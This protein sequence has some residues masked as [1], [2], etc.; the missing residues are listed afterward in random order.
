[1][2]DS[3]YS[4]VQQWIKSE[5]NKGSF[6]VGEKIPSENELMEKFNF[7]RQ[8]I[9]LAISNLENE[10]YVEKVKGSGTFVKGKRSPQSKTTKNI[11][12]IVRYLDNF[13]NP[14]IIKG[15][16]SILTVNG[17]NILLGITYNKW[18]KE[19]ATLN[20]MLDK[21]IDGLLIE[22]CKTAIPSPNK[23]IY[24]KIKKNVPCVFINHGYSGIEIPSVSMDGI[25]G[26]YKAANCLIKAGHTQ[27]ACIFKADDIQGHK[28]YEGY[29]KALRHEG[30]ALNDKSCIWYNS[31]DMDGLL[32]ASIEQL[33]SK[34]FSNCTAVIC[35]NDL[36]AISVINYMKKINKK[37]FNDLSLIS[38]GNSLPAG[39]FD[40]TSISHAKEVLGIKAA[41]SLLRQI[42]TGEASSFL[43]EPEIIERD[44]VVKKSF[45]N[46]WGSPSEL[47]CEN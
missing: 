3:K 9:R 25:S 44:S 18:E 8:T 34:R 10:G 33:F 45:S 20:A 19:A 12:V 6:K 1:M 23:D 5:I 27:I 16:E 7:S 13:L 15:I 40:I 22:G 14:E 26:G 43:M 4:I 47:E 36:V 2:K 28:R 17:Y 29:I 32:N 35:H 37:L 11:G 41:E 42:K 46:S 21:N 24:L 31:E 39:L 30:I 38:F